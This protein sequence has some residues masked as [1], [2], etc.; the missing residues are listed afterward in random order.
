MT[1]PICL[2]WPWIHFDG[3]LMHLLRRELDG[4]NFYTLPSKEPAPGPRLM[5]AMP[6]ERVGSIWR[7]SISFLEP[8]E[9]HT[10]T[11]Y[12]RFHGE[13]AAQMP[14]KLRY[15]DRGRGPF[16]DWMMKMPYA[17]ANQITFYAHGDLAEV[18]RLLSFLPALGKKTA[19]G[20]GAFHSISVEEYPE[21]RSVVWQGR[22]MR[23]IPMIML[24]SAEKTMNTAYNAPYWDKRGIAECARPGSKIELKPRWRM[25]LEGN[26]KPAAMIKKEM[27]KSTP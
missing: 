16:R 4:P 25:M 3:L 10:L 26:Y 24:D 9:L 2:G 5:D 23:P 8:E 20:F 6:L 11:L 18:L 27:R 14:W 22:A 1:T 15:V 12:K 17:P 13:G 7:A 19:Y 21:D